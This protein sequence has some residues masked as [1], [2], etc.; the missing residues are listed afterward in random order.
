MKLLGK[1]Y[2]LILIQGRNSSLQLHLFFISER[3]ADRRL[4]N[5]SHH[6][7]RSPRMHSHV[8]NWPYLFHSYNVYEHT[9]FTQEIYTTAKAGTLNSCIHIS[10]FKFI[11][12]G[13]LI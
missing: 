5:Q 2:G 8:D 4:V 7:I 6:G 3:S 10:R 1:L 12:S 13:L 9:S 11:E